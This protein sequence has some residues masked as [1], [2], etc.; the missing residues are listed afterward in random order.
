[1]Y[2]VSTRSYYRSS[3]IRFIGKKA[4]TKIY[5]SQIIDLCIVL[6][7][8]WVRSLSVAQMGPLPQDL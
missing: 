7:F 6:H 3:G 1:M 2:R 4:F 8:E 5:S